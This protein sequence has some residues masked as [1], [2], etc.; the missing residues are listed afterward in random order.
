MKKSIKNEFVEIQNRMINNL[1]EN[2]EIR[3]TDNCT[4]YLKNKELSFELAFMFSSYDKCSLTCGL[5][6]EESMIIFDFGS[7][8]QFFQNNFEF[9]AASK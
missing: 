3:F 1:P 4:G 2:L 7:I 8:V 5:L 9:F 6:G